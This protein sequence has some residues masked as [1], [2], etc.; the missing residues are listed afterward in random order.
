MSLNGVV[1]FGKMLVVGFL[2]ERS[3]NKE[4]LIVRSRC[5]WLMN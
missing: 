1:L 5:Q 4:S 3:R 2:W